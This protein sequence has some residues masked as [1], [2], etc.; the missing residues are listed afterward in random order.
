MIAG[1][2]AIFIAATETLAKVIV[3]FALGYIITIIAVVR[4]LIGIRVLV[5]VTPAILPV[6]LSGQEALL[7]TVV[8]GLPKQIGAVL[9]RLIIAAATVVT[10]VRSRV[11]IWIIVEIVVLILETRVLLTQVPHILLLITVLRHASLLLKRCFMLLPDTLPL[12]QI[13]P[14]LGQTLLLLPNKLLLTLL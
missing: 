6:S 7:I 2:I 12:I 8:H 4:V 14:I 9:I 1:V 5:V 13:L 3:V 11:E 10:I